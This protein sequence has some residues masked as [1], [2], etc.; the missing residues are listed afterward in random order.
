MGDVLVEFDEK[1]PEIGSTQVKRQKL[2][3]LF[4]NKT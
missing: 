4:G 3:S 2:A 1:Y